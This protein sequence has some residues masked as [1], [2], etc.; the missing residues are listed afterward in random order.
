MSRRLAQL[1]LTAVLCAIAWFCLADRTVPAA[2]VASA[3][4]GTLAASLLGRVK[5][6]TITGLAAGVL[7]SVLLVVATTDPSGL[8]VERGISAAET[9]AIGTSTTAI[10]ALLFAVARMHAGSRWPSR[11]LMGTLLATAVVVWFVVFTLLA[12][13]PR[14]ATYDEPAEPGSYSYDADLYLQTYQYMENGDS[15]Y[16]ALVKAGADD[17]RLQRSGA[18]KNGVFVDWAPTVTLVRQPVLFYLWK[19]AAASGGGIVVLSILVSALVLV[20]LYWAL[21]PELGPWAAFVPIA[22]IPQ[23]ASH[24]VPPNAFLPDWWAALAVCLSIA[25]LIRRHLF[26]ALVLALIGALFREVAA[27]W[28]AVLVVGVAAEFVR[29]PRRRE[30]TTVLV[31]IACAALFGVAM[32]VHY[33]LAAS[34]VSGRTAPGRDLAGIFATSMARGLG[35]RFFAPAS[36][37]MGRYEFWGALPAALL[38]PLG[39]LGLLLL[40]RGSQGYVRWLPVAYLAMWVAFTLAIGPH[41]VYWGQGYTLLAVIGC[42]V[43]L[44]RVALRAG[45]TPA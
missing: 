34:I 2:L 21:W 26:A 39:L 29:W 20:T 8:T 5:E 25:C 11:R 12:V 31:A 14:L 1:A 32:F 22:L 44:A 37:L 33:G 24:A 38:L 27:L 13:S 23:M 6:A 41:S 16:H 43:A 10:A 18:V 28:L 7:G 15:Y 17:L 4:S 36:Y 30:G 19:Y 9:I 42:G 40:G 3:I 35:E 45:P